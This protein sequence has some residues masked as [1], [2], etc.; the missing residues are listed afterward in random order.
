MEDGSVLVTDATGQVERATSDALAR[1][2][3]RPTALVRRDESFEE[4]TTISDWLN[5]DRTITAIARAQTGV[6]VAGTLK[7]ADHNYERAQA[8]LVG[9]LALSGPSCRGALFR[10]GKP[11]RSSNRW[12]LG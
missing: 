7:H 6:H 9:I 4:C 12:N 11:T 8:K 10:F 3:I 5:S 2:R 1:T